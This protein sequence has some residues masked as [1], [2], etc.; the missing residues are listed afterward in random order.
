MKLSRQRM[1]CK[2]KLTGKGVVDVAQTNKHY[3]LLTT[4][5]F[6]RSGSH[7]DRKFFE[8]AQQ[9]SSRDATIDAEI[10]IRDAAVSR[11]MEKLVGR[12]GQVADMHE[13]LE[14][15][16]SQIDDLGRVKRRENVNLDYLKSV[17]VQFLS[18]PAG[19]SERKHLLPVLAT[20]LQFGPNDYQA[21]QGGVEK[22]TSFWSVLSGSSSSTVIGGNSPIKSSEN[23]ITGGGSASVSVGASASVARQ[24]PAAASP[25]QI[26]TTNNNSKQGQKKFEQP[27]QTKPRRTSMQF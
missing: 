18:K 26:S 5:L 22:A 23:R 12:D 16:K 19:S 11:M 3:F 21:I 2:W 24:T 6:R 4:F 25:K 13:I 7:Q 14:R 8:M 20:L 10:E 17:V 9:Q 15:S 27:K 1:T